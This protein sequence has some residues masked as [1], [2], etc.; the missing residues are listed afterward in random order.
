MAFSLSGA[1]CSLLV[2]ASLLPL[3]GRW[4]SYIGLSAACA[5]A[6]SAGQILCAVLWMHESSLFGYLPILLLIS[7][8]TGTLTGTG[9]NLLA[10]RLPLSLSEKG[11]NG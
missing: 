8:F 11:D 6:H 1:L 3:R 4:L 7:L 9:A 2:L 10:E 5:A